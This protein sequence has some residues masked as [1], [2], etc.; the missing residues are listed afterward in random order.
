MA[1]EISRVEQAMIT[2]DETVKQFAMAQAPEVG[3]TFVEVFRRAAIVRKLESLLTDEVMTV[4]IIPL[5]DKSFGFRTDEDARVAKGKSPYNVH[6]IRNVMID[7][8]MRGLRPTNNELNVIAGNCYMAKNGAKRLVREF[9][10]LTDLVLHPG[11]PKMM[12]GGAVV[13]MT[14]DFKLNGKPMRLERKGAEAFAI[15]LIGD[16]GADAALGKADRKMHAYI[17]ETLTGTEHSSADMDEIDGEAK[18]VLPAPGEAANGHTKELPPAP[19]TVSRTEQLKDAMRTQETKRGSANPTNQKPAATAAPAQTK[20]KPKEQPKPAPAP[21]PAPAAD[22]PND[23]EP[24]PPPANDEELMK[25]AKATLALCREQKIAVKQMDPVIKDG[26]VYHPNLT[27]TGA[28][29]GASPAAATVPAGVPTTGEEVKPNAAPP[30][31]HSAAPAQAAAAAA[32]AEPAKQATGEV[33]TA[34]SEITNVSKVKDSNPTCW[35]MKDETSGQ[36]ITEDF[37]LAKKFKTAY[38][39]KIK[40]LIEYVER[41]ALT[42]KYGNKFWEVVGIS[43]APVDSDMPPGADVWPGDDLGEEPAAAIENLPETPQ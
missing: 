41:S 30:T 27:P 22:K 3:K 28:Y 25:K 42:E 24:A 10:G 37:E 14:A 4:A 15:R 23:F 21:E 35:K 31:E 1:N 7:A 9:P 38:E 36:Y 43:D 2:L 33:L 26:K 19:Q 20:E 11:T 12:Q 18:V 39:K 8:I 13:E 34:T 29:K 5:K 32:P 16:Q 17:L 40:Q 6:Q